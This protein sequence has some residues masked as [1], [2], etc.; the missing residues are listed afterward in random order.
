MKAKPDAPF[1]LLTTTASDLAKLLNEGATTSVKI[2]ETYLT[3][4]KK[5]NRAGA[6][7]HAIISTA[8][9]PLLEQI[10]AQLD[11]ERKTGRLRSSLHGIPIIVKVR[12]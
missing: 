7:L 5:H 12:T 4:I 10:A 11:A 1:D 8:P 3:Q 2:V 6:K 9:A